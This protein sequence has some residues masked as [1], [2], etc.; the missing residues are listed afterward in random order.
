MKCD[1]LCFSFIS[2]S[3][4][5]CP[6]DWQIEIKAI[7]KTV[8]KGN[9]NY[10]NIESAYG[11]NTQYFT[12]NGKPFTP[13]AGELHFSRVP[14]NR[15]RESL[16][17]MRECGITVVSNYVFWNYHEEEKNVF[18]FRCNRDIASFLQICRDI[19]MPCILRIGPW[20]HG[21]VIRGGLPKRI[22]LMVKKRCDDPKYLA[23]VRDYWTGPYKEVKPFLDGKTVIGLQLENEYTGATE[24]IRTLRRIAEEIGF[25]VPFFAMTA[26][27]YALNLNLT[28]LIFRCSAVNRLSMIILIQTE[29]LLCVFVIIKNILIKIRL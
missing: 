4:P 9:F 17:K 23:E 21:E 15:W 13:I 20:C 14:R 5:V 2:D 22:N 1:R 11:V 16:L 8:K 24:H 10:S 3:L 18:D 27:M 7:P 12:K 26:S 19:D 25:K 28:G 6:A 29:S